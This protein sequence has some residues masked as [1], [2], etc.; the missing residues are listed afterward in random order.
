MGVLGRWVEMVRGGGDRVS[1][2]DV[3]F[4]E[5]GRSGGDGVI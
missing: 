5:M 1:G 3:G 4:G 2:G